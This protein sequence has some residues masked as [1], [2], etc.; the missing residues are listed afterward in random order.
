MNHGTLQLNCAHVRT[1]FV[2]VCLAFG[3]CTHPQ[4]WNNAYNTTSPIIHHTD[5]NAQGAQSG[6]M[7]RKKSKN[8]KLNKTSV[9]GNYD[10]IKHQ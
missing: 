4:L 7:T 2:R 9:Q 8:R 10:M 5:I 6:A 1:T 3:G